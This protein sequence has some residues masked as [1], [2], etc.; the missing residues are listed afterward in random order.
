M[1]SFAYRFTRQDHGEEVDADASTSNN[2][3]NEDQNSSHETPTASTA[4]TAPKPPTTKLP[5]VTEMTDEN[6]LNV[7]D[8]VIL[9]NEPVVDDDLLG[10]ITRNIEENDLED[11]FNMNFQIESVESLHPSLLPFDENPVVIDDSL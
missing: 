9:V 2:L 3:R 8:D 4:S 11:A 10:E 1:M 5:P 6:L 7:S